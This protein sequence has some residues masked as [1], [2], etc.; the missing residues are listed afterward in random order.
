M[1]GYIK[2]FRQ[3]S[4]YDVINLFSFSGTLPATKG[5]VVKIAGSGWRSTD[6]PNIMLGGIGSTIPNTVSQRWGVLPK[7]Q[8]CMSGDTPFGILLYD[9]REVDENGDLLISNPRKRD[10]MQC[11][12]SGQAVPI[13]TR[14]LFLYSGISGNPTAGGSAH[15][16]DFGTVAPSNAGAAASLL[17]KFLGAKADDNTILLKLDL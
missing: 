11:V 1:P 15:A 7:V 3:V 5:T 17:G 10:E 13:A 2:G 6:D 8:V 4:E 9:V 14:G 16:T 12:L